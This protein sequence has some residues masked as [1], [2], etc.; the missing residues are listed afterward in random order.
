VKFHILRAYFQC[1]KLTEVSDK[2]EELNHLLYGYQQN[3][4]DL[5]AVITENE[6]SLPDFPHPCTCGKCVRDY[7]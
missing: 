3:M 1:R 6:I 7:V 2:P 5:R 4:D